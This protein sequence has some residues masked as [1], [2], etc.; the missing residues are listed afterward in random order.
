MSPISATALDQ[1]PALVAP[2]ARREGH[3]RGL[4]DADIPLG[5]RLMT[6]VDIF[7]ALTASDRP[8][9]RALPLEGALGILEAEAREGKLDRSLIQLWIDS[10]AWEDIPQ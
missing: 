8:Y 1:E 6:I 2:E 7:D 10:R 3:P 9:K 4:V 5:S